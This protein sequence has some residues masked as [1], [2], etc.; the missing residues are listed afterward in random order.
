V[1]RII[2]FSRALSVAF[3]L[4]LLCLAGTGPVLAED[5]HLYV[6]WK[7]LEPDK[8]ASAWLIARFADKKAKFRFLEKGTLTA[9]GIPFDTPQ[10]KF[11]ATHSTTTFGAILREYKLHE[12]ALAMLDR[13]IRDIELNRWEKPLTEEGRG[14]EAAIDG[15]RKV[16][17]ET[18]EALQKSFVLFDWLYAHFQP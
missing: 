11:R 2:N 17:G 12:P 14:I 18:V 6:T 5:V 13:I 16:E 9:E 3:V 10:A 1:I 15:L 8:C 4:V 7:G